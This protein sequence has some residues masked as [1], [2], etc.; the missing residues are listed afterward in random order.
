MEPL[1]ESK[2]NNNMV[3]VGV[4]IPFIGEKEYLKLFKHTIV[5][6]KRDYNN[7]HKYFNMSYYPD[8]GFLL[9]KVY[10]SYKRMITKIKNIGFCLTQ[11]FYREGYKNEYENFIANICICIKNLVNDGYIIHLIPF[12][13]SKKK[14][15]ENDLIMM[16]IIKKRIPH[17]NIIIEYDSSYNKNNYIELVYKKISQMDFNICTRFHGHIFSLINHVPFVSLSCSRK[18]TEFMHDIDFVNNLYKLET[19]DVYLPIDFSGQLFYKFIKEKFTNLDNINKKLNHIMKNFEI[20]MNDFENHWKNLIYNVLST[21]TPIQLFPGII[22]IPCSD[23]SSPPLL[24][25][26]GKN[27]IPAIHCSPTND[28][29]PITTGL[30]DKICNIQIIIN[31]YFQEKESDTNNSSPTVVMSPIQCGARTLPMENTIA[32]QSYPYI[33]INNFIPA[34]ANPMHNHQQL[35]NNNLDF[36][37]ENNS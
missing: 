13:I 7:L 3:A 31:N 4:G 17:E 26:L 1:I 36:N 29:E 15:D 37:F 22:G 16:N 33:I 9:P 8:I 32:W 10:G 6:N 30:D 11:T 20:L 27:N 24:C 34:S 23:S 21:D 25:D 28:P 14:Q 19:N 18:C 35:Y 5:R 12:C 2:N